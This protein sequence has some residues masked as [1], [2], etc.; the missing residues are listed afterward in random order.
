MKVRANQSLLSTPFDTEAVLPARIAH[1]VGLHD[2]LPGNRQRAGATAIG[3]SAPGVD[4]TAGRVR[5]CG[6]QRRPRLIIQNA[7]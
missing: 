5:P 1:R 7:D 4:E 2:Y 3:F 6:I